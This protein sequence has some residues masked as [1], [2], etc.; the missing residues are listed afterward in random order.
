MAKALTPRRAP[1]DPLAEPGLV[2]K[3]PRKKSRKR[4]FWKSKG[5]EAGRTPGGGPRAVVARPPKAPEDFSR[6]WRAL[7]E[8]ESK[9]Q[10]RIV[11]QKRKAIPDA[12]QRREMGTETADTEAIAAPVPSDSPRT[13]KMPAPR[14]QASRAE[15]GQKGARKRTDGNT[16]PEAGDLRHKK[17]RAK[18]VTLALPPALP[19]EEDI[20]FDDVAPAGIEA[21]LGPEAARIARKQL[22]RSASAITLV[23]E[24]A[25]GGLTRALA[26][27]C[28]MVGVGP[29]GEESIAARVSIVNQYGKCV[30]DKYVKPTQPVTDYRTAV[31]GIR[32]ESLKQGERLEVIQQEVADLL[33][34]RILV[35]H[36]LHND[37]KVLFLDHPKKKIRD[38]QKYKPFKSQVKSGRPSLKLLA[39]RL[40]GIR[41]QE[42][43][44]CSI[45]DAQTAM[46]LYILVKKEWE[47][48]AQDRRP[49]APAPD[50][51]SVSVPKR[52]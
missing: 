42:A 28:E 45:Q 32:P 20:W 50:G 17:W 7:R 15:H 4:S 8:T 35:G 26:M 2:Q 18:E 44:H 36:A 38:T 34:G 51:G 33:K 19:T 37:L 31:S 13:R 52:S 22:G 27:D 39:E 47:S 3:P 23:E 9:K 11:A 29:K 40:L 1:G 25:F 5:R 21:A 24:Q 12:A 43:E 41:V 16:S 14:T 46:R 48:T 10:P 49:T 30:Y 6:N